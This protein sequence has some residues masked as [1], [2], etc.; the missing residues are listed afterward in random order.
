MQAMQFERQVATPAPEHL[1]PVRQ[2][3]E[4]EERVERYVQHAAEDYAEARRRGAA[5]A[6]QEVGEHV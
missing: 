2:Q 5:Y 6:A 4:H 3:H 1:L